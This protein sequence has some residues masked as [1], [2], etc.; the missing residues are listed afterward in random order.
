MLFRI[1]SCRAPH[2]GLYLV[3]RKR[4]DV[5][6][7]R[8]PHRFLAST[9]LTTSLFIR[10]SILLRSWHTPAHEITLAH[11][12]QH[13]ILRHH[14]IV[15]PLC[16]QQPLF[17]SPP[18]FV[19]IKQHSLILRHSSNPNQTVCKLLYYNLKTNLGK[20]P[21]H[22]LLFSFFLFL[23]FLFFPTKSVVVP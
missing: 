3:T 1:V 2:A 8:C 10:A 15:H 13:L 16:G 18:N 9:P 17:H 6:S 4:A 19:K 23:F 7:P 20:L 11:T 5:F 12:V 21:F 14:S 22:I